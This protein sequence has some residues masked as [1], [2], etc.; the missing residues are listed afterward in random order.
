MMCFYIGR[1][2]NI[3]LRINDSLSVVES[4]NFSRRVISELANS[5]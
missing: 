1:I 4:T 3:L 2:A 5:S